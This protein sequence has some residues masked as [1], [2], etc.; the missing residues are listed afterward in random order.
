MP[1]YPYISGPAGLVATFGQLR[2]GFPT[3]VDAG[4]LKR[5]NIAPANE[6]YVI[7]IL[8][9]LGLID[10]EGNRV[11]D[12]TDYFWGNDDAFASGLEGTL[13]NAYQMLFDEMGGDAALDADKSALVHWFRASDKTSDLVG[14]RQA[15]TFQTLAAL[16]GHGDLPP[17]RSTAAK[18]TAAAGNTGA[19]KK[20]TAVRKVAPKK[21]AATASATGEGDGEVGTGVKVQ[22]GQDVGLTVR[23]EVNLPPGGDADTYDAIFASIKKHLMS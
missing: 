18:K 12:K 13:R 10:E 23:V 21:E 5:F 14:Q 20:T 19:T 8:K 16:A 6:S 9:F 22:T 1:N 11:E 3:K 4:Y 7:S 17:V 15:T 2:K